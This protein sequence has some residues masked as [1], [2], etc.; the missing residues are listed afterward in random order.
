MEEARSGSSAIVLIG[1]E[2]GVGKTRLV[3]EVTSR[4][5]AA[6]VRVL[7]GGC[8]Q[9]GAE[10]LP[11]GPL[12][13]AL[14]PIPATLTDDDLAALV[15]TGGDALTAVMPGL[16]QDHGPRAGVDVSPGQTLEQLLLF[17]GRLGRWAPVLLVIEDI[18]WADPTTLEFLAF[19]GRNLRDAS[20]ALLATYRTDELTRRHPVRPLLAELERSGH[21]A[22][23]VLERF[24][25]RELAAQ[26][27]GIRGEPADPEVVAAVFERSEGNAFLAEELFAAA[28][29][30]ASRTRCRTCCCC[31]RRRFPRGPR[32]WCESP[33]SADRG[34]LG[35]C[36]RCRRRARHGA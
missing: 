18:H 34:R 7:E 1:G 24:D 25:R 32:S 8:V 29:P 9:L 13:E 3:N 31:G 33:R 28:V 36:R 15:G 27:E 17:L 11:Y 26:L 19:A 14:R 35:D 5:R 23:V 20:V 22:R 10:H 12:I 30:P 2:A 16:L 4:A 21:A 6:G